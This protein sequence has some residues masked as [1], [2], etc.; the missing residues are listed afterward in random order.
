[1]RIKKLDKYILLYAILIT[2]F[3]PPGSYIISTGFTKIPLYL[4]CF[5]IILMYFRNGWKIEKRVFSMI[6]FYLYCFICSSFLNI[7]NVNIEQAIRY[8]LSSICFLLL[9]EIGL[10]Y[11]PDVYLK[12]LLLGAGVPCLIHMYTMF[13]YASSHGMKY[14]L[15]RSP[16]GI[17]RQ[18]WYYLTHANASFFILFPVIIALFYYLYLYNKKKLWIAYP[19]TLISLIGYIYANSTTSM[20]VLGIFVIYVCFFWNQKGKSFIRREIDKLFGILT[21]KWILL[22]IVFFAVFLIV[23]VHITDQFERIIIALGK[24]TDLTSRF[25]IWTKTLEMFKA[26]PVRFVFGFGWEKELV[27]I[28]KIGINHC[29]NILLEILYRGG[30]IGFILFL[31]FTIKYLRGLTNTVLGRILAIGLIIILLCSIMD[32]YLYRFEVFFTYVMIYYG[33]KLE[34]KQCALYLNER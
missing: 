28:R 7:N 24:T 32:F 19:I 9:A 6:V 14:G 21:N 17:S 15:V 18:A 33:N 5:I 23:F 3:F 29:H 20:I 34:N 30:L 27:T 12:S 25:P 8:S 31:N 1:M 4:S 11:R 13:K 22:A 26:N 2:F 10:K 16:T